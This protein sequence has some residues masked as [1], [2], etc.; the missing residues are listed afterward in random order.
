MREVIGDNWSQYNPITNLI[1][2]PLPRP[3]TS[4]SNHLPTVVTLPLTEAAPIQE[5][6]GTHH[7]YSI[8]SLPFL[9]SISIGR[10]SRPCHSDESKSEDATSQECP[11]VGYE[12]GEEGDGGIRDSR[13]SRGDVEGCY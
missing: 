3:L 8:I 4:H 13:E 1:V 11:G 9:A 5:A 10:P 6:Q 12:G 2:R 7:L